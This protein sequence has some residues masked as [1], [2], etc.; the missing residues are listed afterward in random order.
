MERWAS[1]MKGCKKDIL[2][3]EKEKWDCRMEKCA[4][5]TARSASTIEMSAGNLD[6]LASNEL[7]G[8]WGNS[9]AT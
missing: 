2:E 6:L 4:S 5:T 8:N 7:T 1:K 9:Q 3:N